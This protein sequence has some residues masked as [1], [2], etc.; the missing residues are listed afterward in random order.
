MSPIKLVLSSEHIDLHGQGV[1]HLF[2]K[3]I[4]GALGFKGKRKK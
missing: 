1:C 3:S 4:L 2:T